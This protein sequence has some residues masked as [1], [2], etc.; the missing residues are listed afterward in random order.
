[1]GAQW[2]PRSRPLLGT[3]ALLSL[4]AAALLG[5]I[6]LHQLAVVPRGLCGCTQVPKETNR[7]CQ[8]GAHSPGPQSRPGAAPT[9]CDVPPN[10]RF[11]CAPDKAITQGECEA[12]GCC[13]APVGRPRGSRMGPP[14]CFFP[15]SYPSYRLGNLTATDTGYTA[16]LT[17]A[18]PTFLP[19]DILTLRLDVLLETESRLHFT[20]G[21]WAEAAA[22]GQGR[23]TAPLGSAPPTDVSG[24]PAESWCE[25]TV[26]TA[27]SG[28]C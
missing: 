20:V 2:P 15:P 3:C 22:W 24:A 13:Y 8:Q 21:G 14:W 12:R 16:R 6:L 9:Q 1:M 10:S 7:A 17:R 18:A 23:D 19:K 26:P 27:G 28:G 5:H 25:Q 11:D 4:A